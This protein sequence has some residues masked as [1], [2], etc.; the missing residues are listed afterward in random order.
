VRLGKNGV[1]EI[2]SYGA[3]SAF[4]QQA[5]NDMLATLNSDIKEGVD[6]INS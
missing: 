4:E 3:L 5:K 6:F 2:L 1:E